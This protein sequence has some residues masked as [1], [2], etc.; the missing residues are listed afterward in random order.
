MFFCVAV[1]KDGSAL[2]AGSSTGSW[3]GI[4]LG[5]RDFVAVKVDSDG[6]EL[7]RW[8]VKRLSSTDVNIIDASRSNVSIKSQ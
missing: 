5:G 2:L 4:H 8:Q 1:G 6:K 3:D 7:W